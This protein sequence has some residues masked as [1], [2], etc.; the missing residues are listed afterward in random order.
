MLIE[1][2]LFVKKK[3]SESSLFLIG[4]EANDITAVLAELNFILHGIRDYQV[5]IGDSLINPKFEKADKVVANPPWNQDGYDENTLKRNPEHN[6]IFHFGYTAKKSADWAWLQLISYYAEKKAAVVLDSG[7]LFRGGKE[8]EIRKA[9]VKADLIDAIILL[10]EKIFYNTQAPGII[11][12]IN[13]EKDERRRGKVLFINAS[14]EYI[15]HP[16]IRKLNKLSDENIEKIAKAY[17]EYKDI[18]DFSRVVDLKEIEDKDFN[19]NV[20]LYVVPKEEKEEID[21]AEEFKRMEELHREYLE[22]YEVV[23]EYLKELKELV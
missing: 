17:R 14:N 13:K 1:Q 3:D 4:Q 12:V 5:Y 11:V 15:Q 2:Y 6:E 23:R 16:E 7:A 20:S 10:P 9:F 19:L 22:K 18:P 8:Q 21:L